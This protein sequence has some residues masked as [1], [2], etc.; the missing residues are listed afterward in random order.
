MIE[1][2]ETMFAIYVFG[3]P[4]IMTITRIISRDIG[5]YI[6]SGIIFSMLYMVY[7]ILQ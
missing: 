4:I 5:E 7:Y 3:L 2:Q 6:S 1:Q